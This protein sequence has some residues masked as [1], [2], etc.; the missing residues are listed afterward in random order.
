MKSK[1]LGQVGIPAGVVA[2]I[3]M[4]VVPLPTV[5]LDMLIALNIAFA[6][7]VLLVSMFVRRALDFAVFP[8]LILIA[9]LFRLALNVS[10]TRLVLR[11]GFA[12]H[13][14]ESFGHFV[15]G[16]S[17]VIG[18][19]IF[20]IL[21]IIQFM[22]ITKGAERV[23][24]VGARFTLDAM[25][26]KQM[27]I[28]ADLNAGII[29]EDEARRRREDVAAEA[30]FYGA[31]DGASKFVKGDA[32]A[33]III[34][35]INLLGGF[36]V[37]VVQKGMAPGEAAHTYSLLSI[38]DGLVSQIPALLLSV[39]TG[40]IVTRSTSKADMGTD[41]V[42]QLGQQR[43][44]LRIG[45]F[46]LLGLCL[47]PGLPKLPFLVVGGG[48]FF[49]STKLK[50][51]SE[52]AAELEGGPD[53][54]PAGAPAPDSPEALAEEMLVDSLA[55]E[56]AVDL[57]DLVDTSAGGDLLERVRALRRKVALDLGIVLPPVRTRDDL[58]LPL[59]TYVI[60]I[61]GVAA[62]RGEAPTGHVLAIGESLEGLPGTPTREPVFGLAAKWVPAELRHQAELLGATVVDRAS[63]VTTHLA[64]VVREGASRLLGREDVRS[65]VDMVKRTHPVVVEELTPA[66][67][68]LGEVQRVLQALLDEGVSIRDL[69]RIFEALSLRAKQGTDVEGLV[70]SA[71]AALGPAIA[72]AYA[73]DGVLRC[74]TLDPRLEQ[75]MFESMVAGDGG[76]HILLDAA[77]AEAVTNRLAQLAEV[78]E[79]RGTMPVLV[80][81][82]Q[83]RSAV[84]RLTRNAAPRVPVLSYGEV[85]GQLQIETMGVVDD[86]H[87]PA[88]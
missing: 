6:L 73:P 31:M 57:V 68:T 19:V 43:N 26:G 33:A 18:L 79:Q 67:L 13:V 16:G 35:T 41:F 72:A 36:V 78:A 11:D 28:D 69:P 50:K 5:V 85:T 76:T 24:E 1:N 27:A 49:L 48:V 10:A 42:Q 71:R 58:E 14:I 51:P 59:S 25:P 70:E 64:E 83:V 66:A 86:A 21:V 38:G 60:K 40:L 23:A 53:A 44:A 82:P 80:C 3:L 17:L 37:G 9:T 87:A 56:L 74:F 81:S 54:L 88:A 46:A 77:R 15:V 52:Q 8:S 22:V 65:L 7:L 4:L 47:I 34:T 75:A 55:L 39:A 12:G 62:A 45:A 2:I 84:R 61:G 30:D 20:F 29:D 32:I 63:V